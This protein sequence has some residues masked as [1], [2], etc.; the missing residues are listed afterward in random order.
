MFGCLF[1]LFEEEKLD[2]EKQPAT[3]NALY[4]WLSLIPCYIVALLMFKTYYDYFHVWRKEHVV[5]GYEFTENFEPGYE[6]DQKHFQGRW[7][8]HSDN[9]FVPQHFSTEEE[10]SI[11][12][13]PEVTIALPVQQDTELNREDREFQNVQNV[14]NVATRIENSTEENDLENIINLVK[15]GYAINSKDADNFTLLHR[16]AMNNQLDTV[17]YL[18][19]KGAD[20][21]E[22]RGQD[23][24]SALHEA[25]SHGHLEIVTILVNEGSAQIFMRNNDG[26]NAFRIA[27][28]GNHRAIRRFLWSKH[29]FCDWKIYGLLFLH[30]MSIAGLI[31]I[32]FDHLYIGAFNYMFC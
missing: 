25:I 8:A 30:V 27:R 31:M 19:K 22:R 20:V 32:F 13:R 3:R 17:K 16:A 15:S 2:L 7:V 11:I 9:S 10:M 28:I 14:Q 23:G 21:D 24:Q 18:I 12:G 4:M 1:L 29:P 26:Q 6:W 5:V